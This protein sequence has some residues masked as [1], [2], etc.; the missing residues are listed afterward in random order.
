MQFEAKS[1]SNGDLD[2]L[3]RLKRGTFCHRSFCWTVF[4]CRLVDFSW[5]LQFDLR[6]K[7]KENFWEWRTKKILIYYKN[8]PPLLSP[9]KSPPMLVFSVGLACN[10]DIVCIVLA[11]GLTLTVPTDGVVR[12]KQSKYQVRYTLII[13]KKCWDKKIYLLTWCNRYC[14]T[15]R[16]HCLRSDSVG[17]WIREATS[18]SSIQNK[19]AILTTIIIT[20]RLN[21]MLNKG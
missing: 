16:L 10:V 6:T 5:T 17:L 13:V 11:G 19:V 21:W 4:L 15:H 18:Q 3:W 14:L 8:V 12:S 20:K 2:G 9:T 7:Q 1:P